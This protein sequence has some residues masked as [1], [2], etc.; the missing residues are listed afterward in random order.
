MISEQLLRDLIAE[1]EEMAE[2]HA[3]DRRDC[4]AMGSHDGELECL[5]AERDTRR[6]IRQGRRA[7]K[8]MMEASRCLSCGSETVPQGRACL[9]CW[10]KSFGG[11]L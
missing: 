7:L 1:A 5:K 9:S 8:A 10:A 4:R 2:R 6:I 3:D 11:G